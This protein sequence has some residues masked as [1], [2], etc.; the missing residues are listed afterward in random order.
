MPI[1]IIPP[2]PGL[3]ARKKRKTRLPAVPAGPSFHWD[4]NRPPSWVSQA[5]EGGGLDFGG[6]T[7]EPGWEVPVATPTTSTSTGGSALDKFKA[8]IL[9]DPVYQA[10]LAT[11]NANTQNAF[12]NLR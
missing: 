3:P 6:A 1:S 10:G 8:A 4:E 5:S 9:S 2:A 7:G 12:G 11:F